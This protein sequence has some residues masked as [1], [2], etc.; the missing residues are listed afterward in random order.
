MPKINVYLP[1]DLAEAVKDIDLPV[2]AICQR[3]L[4]HAVRRVTAMREVT[5]GTLTAPPDYGG[6]T[7]RCLGM[8]ESAVATA[9]DA[10]LPGAG[11]E[12][13]LA[14]IAA[15]ESG[16]ALRVLNALEITGQQVRSAL[17]GRA[18]TAPDAGAGTDGGSGTGREAGA[19]AAS[20][21]PFGPYAAT[22]MQLA[23]AESAGFGHNYIGSEHILLGLIGEPDG[24]AGGVLRSLGA[25]LRGTRRMVTAALAGWAAHTQH[26][27]L[28]AGPPPHQG[29]APDRAQDPDAALAARIADAVRTELTPVLSRIE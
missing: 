10:G 12:H 4:E 1:D 26:V 8:V 16:M 27:T 18:D 20:R 21:A 22:A 2:S 6:F 28:A 25:E 14:V 29:A 11:T 23:A 5:R 24:V 3:A 15:D 9:R 7:S 13:L 17:D 19:D